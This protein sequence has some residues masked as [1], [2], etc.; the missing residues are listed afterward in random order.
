MT[1]DTSAVTEGAAA[2][3]RVRSW[4]ICFAVNSPKIQ[5]WVND[6]RSVTG[7]GAHWV[8]SQ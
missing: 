3:R 4:S 6:R 8:S 2:R 1:V 5:G 7:Y